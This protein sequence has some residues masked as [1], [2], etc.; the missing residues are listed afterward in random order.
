VASSRREQLPTPQE[1]VQSQ[2]V[3]QHDA[4]EHPVG[5]VAAGPERGWL[6]QVRIIARA[7]HAT[8]GT[9]ITPGQLAL[10]MRVGT[11][12]AEQILDALADIPTAPNTTTHNGAPTTGVPT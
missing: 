4:A 8:H 1:R 9:R 2:R 6:P 10:R 12:I 11:D 5:F 7:H 3:W